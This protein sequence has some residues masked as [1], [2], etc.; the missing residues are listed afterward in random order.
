M[1]ILALQGSPRESG[2]TQAVLDVVLE[3][4]RRA[5]AQTEVIHLSQ[6]KI[7]SGC[8]ECYACQDKP[9]EPGCAIDDGMQAVLRKALAADVVLWATPVFCWSPSWLTKMA[10]DRFFCTFKF[11]DGDVTSLMRGRKVAAVITSG[12]GEDE[13]ADLVKETCRRMAE[14]SKCT[15]L[16][17]LVAGNVTSPETIRADSNLMERARHFGRQLAGASR[18]ST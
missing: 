8:M 17:A 9:D 1:K 14:Y 4:A 16:G 5:G 10:M 7:A 13:G 18:L 15:W 2:N 11:G 12:G 3:E 6:A